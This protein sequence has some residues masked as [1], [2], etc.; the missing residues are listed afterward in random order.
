MSRRPALIPYDP[1]SHADVALDLW[2]AAGTSWA[3]TPDRL[4]GW[5]DGTV[6]VDDDGHPVG[7]VAFDPGGAVELIVVAP[8]HRR[9]GVGSA[10]LEDATRQLAVRGATAL[11]T[12]DGA[13]AIWPGVPDD[14][15]GAS[16][17]F[18]RSGWRIDH[19]TDD[20]TQDLEF[21]AT[22][23]GVFE[24][25]RAA[26]ITFA[27]ES[28]GDEIL[29][30][31]RAEFPSWL[32]FYAATTDDSLI[33][34][35]GDGAVVG[36]ALLGGPGVASP[37]TPMLGERAVTIGC[38]GVAVARHGHGIGT[39]LVATGSEILRDRGARACHISWT[40]RA[41]FYESLGYVRWRSYRM[42]QRP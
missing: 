16:G 10:L 6:A 37:F 32:Q 42:Y 24:V 30:F 8:A 35:S 1:T 9:S 26:A 22:P 33:A 14:L 39:A 20:L 3:L 19:V 2:A 40:T 11:S 4:R 38:V 36:A 15:D 34:R 29:G 25:S 28:A 21:Y 17:L 7:F 41:S 27:V 5:T 23:E 12:S 31:E 18:D 13:H